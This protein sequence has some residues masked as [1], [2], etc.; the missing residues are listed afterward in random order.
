MIE[1]L[2][3]PVK[4]NGPEVRASTGPKIASEPRNTIAGFGVYQP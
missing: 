2:F 3:D 1:H 4:G